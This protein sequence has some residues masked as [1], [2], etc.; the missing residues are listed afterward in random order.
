M[1][2]QPRQ[3]LLDVWRAV[4]RSSRGED[5]AWSWGGRDLPNSISDAEQLLCLMGPATEIETFKLD[6]PDQTA[7]DVLDSLADLGDSVEVPRLLIKVIGEY[8]NTYT[9]ESGSPVFSGGSYFSVSGSNEATEQQL[10][11]DVVDS[12]SASVR[13]C[14]A[15]IG[16]A[17]VFRGV[18]RRE[19][20]RQ[21]VDHLET[22]ASR[23]LTAAMVGL[24]RGF[25]VN[26]FDVG[27]EFGEN[28]L[29]MVDRGKASRRRV[30]EALKKELRPVSAGLRDLSLGGVQVAEL[31]NENKLF[32]CG[33]SW[34][35]T[36]D[37]EEVDTIADVGAQKPGFA[38]PKPYLYF[39]VV[40]L[41]C[42]Q[43]LFS[44]R[45]RL[46]GLLDDE[47][48]RLAG[49]LQLR[50]DLTQSYWSRLARFGGTPWPLE[51][52]PWRTSDGVFSDYLS[53]LV[54][55]IVV[56]EFST[57]RVTDADVF[58][59]GEV[60]KELASRARITRRPV[61]DDQAIA[62]HGP[63]FRIQ[64]LGSENAGGPT[65]TWLLTDF[66][67]QLLKRTVRVA[68]LLRDIEL[69]GEVIALADAVWDDHLVKRRLSG[70]SL[71]DQ[72]GSVFPGLKSANDL[73]S[74]YYTERVVSCLVVAAEY[75][76]GAPLASGPLAD[77]ATDLLA[78]ADH[79]FDQELL[80]VSA[81]AGP[82]M[83]TVLQGIRATL[84]RA[85]DTVRQRPGTAAVLAWDVL[86]ELDR[87]AAARQSAP[88]AG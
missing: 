73:P 17:K 63:G 81:E 84:R 30:V 14:L 46:L 15:T 18:V 29:S 12:F 21:E 55:S 52:I 13:L 35:V 54:T 57:R 67:P 43:D 48:Q 2:I 83:S 47:Q 45:T 68:N 82:A 60:L 80:S 31:D 78:E 1:R 71:W 11:L 10:A 28:L 4:A 70:T 24:I 22:M 40:A 56:Q 72:P 79:L 53:L 88:G 39:T 49:A 64:L 42:I 69:R 6:L 9:D 34:G 44:E 20:L 75:V 25:T 50:W 27:S 5:G 19:S 38:E 86:R 61:S 37:S 33:W 26:S 23:R 65:L 62:L 51:D 8:L 66:A 16:F 77:F 36:S 7:E 59:V 85:Q 87:L 58:R 32:E 74:W 3:Q 41:D 76:T